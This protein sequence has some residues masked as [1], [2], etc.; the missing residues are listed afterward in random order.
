MM[1]IYYICIPPDSQ[2][3]WEAHNKEITINEINFLKIWKVQKKME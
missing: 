2:L 3:F 1:I